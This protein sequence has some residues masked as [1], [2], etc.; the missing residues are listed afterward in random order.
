MP[1]PTIS[2]TSALVRVFL[3]PTTDQFRFGGGSLFGLLSLSLIG[4]HPDS[5]DDVIEIPVA[6]IDAVAD[7][8]GAGD[9]F[10]GGF[11]AARLVG[12][13]LAVSGRIGALCSTYAL[14]NVGTTSHHFTTAEFVNRYTTFFG[15]E[16]ALET[17][18]APVV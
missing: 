17:L 2:F 11:F 16:P 14:E 4:Q 7:P 5:G 8:T 18:K 13:P 15:A 12:L 10:R 9:A 3:S 6:A 1:R